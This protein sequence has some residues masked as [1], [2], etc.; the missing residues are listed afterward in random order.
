MSFKTSLKIVLKADD[1]VVAESEDVE[2]WQRVLSRMNKSG[3]A[4]LPT[5]E[6]PQ[7]D[8]ERDPE[9]A[10]LFTSG[11]Q[12]SESESGREEAIAKFSELLGVNEDELIGACDPRLEPPYIYLEKHHWQEL[13]DTLPARGPNAIPSIVTAA[14]ILLLWLD[15]IGD[16]NPTVENTQ[17]VLNTI[18]VRDR[19]PGRG[20]SNCKWLRKRDGEI[21]LNPAKTSMAVA[22]SRAY[23]MGEKPDFD[24]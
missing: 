15:E 16:E 2:L 17:S 13:K 18:D 3:E 5:G 11:A 12:S 19:N 4:P 14:S 7:R 1:V 10:S 6:P 8:S 21:I 20:I 24:D 22:V 23:C 9:T